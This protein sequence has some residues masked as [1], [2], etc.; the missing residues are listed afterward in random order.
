MGVP[1]ESPDDYLEGNPIERNISLALMVGGLLILLGRRFNW[2]LIFRRNVWILLLLLYSLISC[3]WSDYQFVAFKRA[4]KEVGN[5]I[6]VLVILTEIDCVEA[7]RT[8]FGRAAC[9][10][11]PMSIA[12][13]KYFPN[14]GRSYSQGGVP[15]WCGVTTSKNQLGSLCMLLGLFF[16]WDMVAIWRERRP[17]R[18]IA[19]FVNLVFMGMIF[20]LLI[21]VDSATSLGTLIVGVLVL[22]GVRFSFIKN[23]LGKLL[24][25]LCVVLSLVVIFGGVSSVIETT[26]EGFGRDPTLTGRLEIWKEVLDVAGDP[27]VGTGF[28]SFWL[29]DRAEKFWNKYRWH[30]NQ[31]HNG[32][33]ETY[34]NLGW[35]GVFFLSAVI[36]AA[37]GNAR[38]ALI[39]D[40]HYGRFRIALLIMTLV[41]NITEAAFKGLCLMWFVFLLVALDIPVGSDWGRRIEGS[42][43]LPHA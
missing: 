15:Q 36:I 39:N 41:Y 30:P 16:I 22:A 11:I 43:T 19:I 28:G 10:L 25:L 32:Y 33:L 9:V 20:W 6:M 7:I 2:P 8:I 5:V 18:Q 27:L 40:F 38:N 35:V 13:I 21:T 4:I 26:A 42:E 23:N 14:L 1:L 24:I 31:A 17:D 37:F 12:L 34:I 3:L 29:G